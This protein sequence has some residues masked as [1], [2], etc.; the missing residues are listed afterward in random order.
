[1]KMKMKMKMKNKKQKTENK[2]TVGSEKM[3]SIIRPLLPSS[4]FPT[5]HFA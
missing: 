2:N 1:M 5:F 3:H 4:L